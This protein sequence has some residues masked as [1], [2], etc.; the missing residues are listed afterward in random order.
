[1]AT[2]DA[3]KSVKST[4]NRPKTTAKKSTRSSAARVNKKRSITITGKIKMPFVGAL[5]AEF[6]GVFLLAAAFITGQG[7]PIIVM[8]AAVG[9]ILLVG[10]LSGAHLNPAVTIG[11]WV[12][13]RISWLRAV[14]YIAVQFLGALAA[15]GLLTAF[16]NGA[17]QPEAG[18][19]AFGYGAQLFNASPLP[20]DKEWFVFFAEVIGTLILGFTMAS[21]LRDQ[22]DRLV[23]AFTAG[24]GIFIALLFA[25]SAASYVG[26]SAV[27]NPALA[28]SLEALSWEVWPLAVYV[29]A[30]VIGGVAGFFLNDLLQAN[31]DGGKG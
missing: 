1:M 4:A 8:F 23:S 14:G 19:Q 13:K 6:I 17:A 2:K 31:S 25:V 12:T 24:L 15:L 7:Q 27:I 5:I 11:A 20:I 10:T 30:P 29:L 9:I 26:A 18:A 3:S 21:V 16:V 28:S 22:K